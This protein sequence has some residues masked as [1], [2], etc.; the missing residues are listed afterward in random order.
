MRKRPTRPHETEFL[1][2]LEIVRKRL[3]ER[4]YYIGDV[5]AHYRRHESDF[6]ALRKDAPREFAV[7]R[8][9]ATCIVVR[10]FLENRGA[11]HLVLP[12]LRKSVSVPLRRGVPLLN[13]SRASEYPWLHYMSDENHAELIALG[14]VVKP[15]EAA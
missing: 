6:V 5:A 3:G 13:M 14:C 15:E 4:G 8:M 9:A 1:A 11:F 10:P 2:A 7:V 12:D